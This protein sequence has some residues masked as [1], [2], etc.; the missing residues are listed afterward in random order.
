MKFIVSSTLLLK[1]L[2]QVSGVLNTNNTLPIL[3]H[4]LFEIKGKE[5]RVSVS[6]LETTMI[7]TIGLEKS[8]NDG[9]VCVPAKILLDILKTFAEQPL[10]FDVDDKNFGLEISS[11]HGKY[12]VPGVASSD[13]PKLPEM[14]AASTLS[15][16]A[17]ALYGGINKCLFATGVDDMRPIMSGVFFELNND[18]ITF[19]A[20][21]AHKLVKYTRTD[22]RADKGSTFILPKKPNNLLKNLLT[23]VD[24]EVEIQF[25]DTNARFVMAGVELVC[26]LI[27]G[28]YPNYEAV[29]PKDN[30]NTMTI[31]RQALLNSIRRVSLF[32]NKTTHQIRLKMAGSEL[33][34]SAEDLDFSNEA[35]ERLTCNYEGEDMEIGFNSRFVIEML[36]NLTS[37]QVVFE[38]SAPNRA[39]IIKPVDGN[40]ENEDVLMLVMPIMLNS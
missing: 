32:S 18:N 19:V 30:P 1:Q 2:Q 26:R 11:D 22:A 25:N 35:S 14:S 7:T 13:F 16:G 9:A 15:L 12:K 24:G 36:S 27:D 28:K 40:N 34:I 5:M 37:D 3:D 10:S 8:S 23:D 6:D 17:D 38:M 39:G 31:D 29:I 21:D 20:T 4:F 33:H